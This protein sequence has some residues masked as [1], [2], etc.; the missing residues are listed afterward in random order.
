MGARIS[1]IE[2][3]L[4]DLVVGNVDLIKEFP[5]WDA[6]KIEEKVGIKSRHVASINELQL[7]WQL[8]LLKN[9]F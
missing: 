5:E 9:F 3:Y 7:T 4:P 1:D 2:Y 6:E 8:W